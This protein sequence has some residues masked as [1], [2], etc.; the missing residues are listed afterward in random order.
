MQQFIPNV[1]NK[2]WGSKNARLFGKMLKGRYTS[3]EP[4]IFITKSSR[5]D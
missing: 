3:C 1:Y 4:A 5:R 2:Y